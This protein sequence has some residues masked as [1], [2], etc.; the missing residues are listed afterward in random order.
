MKSRT[1]SFLLLLLIVA[2]LDA[3]VIRRIRFQHGNTSAE[4]IGRFTPKVTENLFVIRASKGQHM[5]VELKPLAPNLITAGTVTSPSGKPDGGPGGVI[6]D[7]DL[8]E[9]G[10]YKIH[11]FE[12]QQNLSGS[13]AVR[14]DIK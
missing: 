4:V 3:A 10:D 12:R 8:T 13:F 1:G 9:T 11:V 5:K 7:G 2:G 14:V 6:F